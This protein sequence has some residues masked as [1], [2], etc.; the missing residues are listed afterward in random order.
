MSRKD[1]QVI[2]AVPVMFT[3]NEEL[4]EAGT[5]RVMENIASAGVV[6][7]F[8]GGTTAEFTALTDP[9]RVRLFQLGAEVFGADRTVAHVG[10]TSAHQAVRLTRAAREIGISR[11]AAISPFYHP[12]VR[13]R[14]VDYY[15][16][17]AQAADGGGVY[18]YTYTELT[19]VGVSPEFLSELAAIP[20]VIGTKVSAQPLSDL[21]PLAAAV[22]DDFEILWGNDGVFDEV[23]AL[24]GAGTVSGVSSVFPSIFAAWSAAL[25]AGDAAAS[26]QWA[27]RARAA[28]AA[29]SCGIGGLKLGLH[30]RGFGTDV[31]RI[32][33]ARPS[34]EQELEIAQLVARY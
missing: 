25:R 28:V 33:T 32:P 3:D 14:V 21:L 34:A 1:Y 9:E 23:T 24:G 11:V 6:Q 26:A 12:S 31:T 5:R 29:V 17:I 19:G 7:A 10:A 13:D 30:L 4:D 22:P 15:Q 2:S 18:V 8:V 27:S 20:G 16:R